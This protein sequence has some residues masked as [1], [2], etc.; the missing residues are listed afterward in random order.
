[1]YDHV[2]YRGTKNF[3]RYC[4]QAVRTAE[5]LKFN[6]KNCFRVN[7]KQRIKMSKQIKLRNHER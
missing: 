1:M 6:F 2:F 5:E 4:L 7:G 3:S